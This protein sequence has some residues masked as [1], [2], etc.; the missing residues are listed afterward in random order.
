MKL[1]VIGN[2]GREHGRAGELEQLPKVATGFVSP[3]NAG[4]AIASKRQKIAFTSY[5][6]L[7]EC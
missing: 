3:G 1:L 7:T 2:G 5:Q 6:E 4:T